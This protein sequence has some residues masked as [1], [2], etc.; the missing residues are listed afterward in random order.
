MAAARIRPGERV[1][2]VGCGCGETTLLAAS[3]AGVDGF[4]LGVDVSE[5]MILRARQ[6]AIEEGTRRRNS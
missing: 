5:P 1:L 6:R 3:A 4:A 2:D